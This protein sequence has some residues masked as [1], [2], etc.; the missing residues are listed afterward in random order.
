[1]RIGIAR[2]VIMVHFWGTW[3]VDRNGLSES[4]SIRRIPSPLK[5]LLHE[6]DANRLFGEMSRL[7][8]CS[9]SSEKLAVI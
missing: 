3:K 1:M 8:G 2:A 7:N 4:Q 9:G 5:D 6:G